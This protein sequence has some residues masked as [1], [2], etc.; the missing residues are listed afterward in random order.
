MDALRKVRD[1]ADFKRTVREI[2]NKGA[3]CS[4]AALGAVVILFVCLNLTLCVLCLRCDVRSVQL[5]G[6]GAA[7]ARSHVQ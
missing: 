3:Y 6:D 4:L 1:S 5:Y 7:R 2:K